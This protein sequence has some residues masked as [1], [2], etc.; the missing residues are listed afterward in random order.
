VETTTTAPQPKAATMSARKPIV[1]DFSIQIATVNGSGSQTSN[2]VLMRTI[3][4]MGVPVSGKNLFPSNIQGLPTWFT[5]RVNK[6]GYVGRKKEIDFMIIMNSETAEEDFLTTEPGGAILIND[7]IKVKSTRADVTVYSVPF[8]KIAA[9]CCPEAKLRKLVVNM[10][11]VGV[12]VYLLDLDLSESEKALSKQLKGKAKAVELNKAAIRAG[13]EYAKT[14]LPKMDPYRVERMNK[15]QGKILIEGNAAAALGACFAGCTIFAWYPITPS[16]SVG[17]AM[18]DYCK[19]FRHDKKTGKP[20][21]S[22][23]QA[24]DELSAIGMTLGAGW[25]GARAMTSTS[26][27]GISLMAEFVG[28]GYYAEIP[29]AIWDVQRIGPSTGLPTRTGQ[30]D[31]TFAL[32]LSHGDKRHPL[33]LPGSVGECF[34]FAQAMF[35]LAER[36]QTVVF[37]L[38]DLDIG[39]NIWMS[40]PFVYPEK[41]YD[42]GKVLSKAELEKIGKFERYRD[43][44][45][46]AIPYRT[47]PGTEHP[48]AA[49]FTRGTGHTEKATYSERPDDFVRN[50]DRLSRKWETIK[51]LVPAPVVDPVAGAKIGI[52]AFGS[53]DQSIRE[54][55]DQLARE[56]NLETS[57][58]RLRA[59]P[60]N[61]EVKQFCMAYDRVYVVEQNRDGQMYDQLC[62]ELRG[63]C[64]R[65]RTVRHYNGFP[66]DARYITDRIKEQEAGKPYVPM[67]SIA[68]RSARKDRESD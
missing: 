68:A 8:A 59:F 55:R 48:L 47:L 6:D 13:F 24:E 57:Y 50:M 14:N 54:C 56:G 5:I 25:A 18:T 4:Q 23:I 12:M 36:A 2:M 22:I 26:G 17:D 1:N 15:T 27:P 67:S 44:D 29:A 60:F 30:Q 3:F 51:K 66:I 28:L 38:S 64:G 10:I 61:E 58:L 40:D 45:G 52:I 9:E 42:R 43:V 21:Y 39:M 62:L 35:D 37:V 20:T 32:N 11:Y 46:D 41:P 49:Y 31:I 63:D 53:T 33:L 7:M 19:R 65:L 16:S 34:E